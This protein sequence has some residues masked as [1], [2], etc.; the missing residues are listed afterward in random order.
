MMCAVHNRIWQTRYTPWCFHFHRWLMLPR[1]IPQG[2]REEQELLLK[3]SCLLLLLLLLFWL[4]LFN[5][6]VI[7][8]SMLLWLFIHWFEKKVWRTVEFHFN[9]I[10]HESRYQPATRS[11]TYPNPPPSQSQEQEVSSGEWGPLIR[12]RGRD[13]VRPIETHFDFSRTRFWGHWLTSVF[14]TKINIIPSPWWEIN[15]WSFACPES[16]KSKDE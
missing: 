14:K 11:K 8:L 5:V 1:Q 4:M 13:E 2:Q 7:V 12:C 9:F 3:V 16:P 15:S 6:I 10:S